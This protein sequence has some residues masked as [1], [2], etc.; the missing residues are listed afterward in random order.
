MLVFTRHRE[1]EPKTTVPPSEM[2]RNWSAER[3]GCVHAAWPEE[4]IANVTELLRKP[5]AVVT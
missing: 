5:P 4:A 2:R 1:R 3:K